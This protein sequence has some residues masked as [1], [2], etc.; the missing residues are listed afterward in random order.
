M[1]CGTPAAW[2]QAP[3]HPGQTNDENGCTH[4]SDD[5]NLFNV[6]VVRHLSCP[7]QHKSF[8]P[9]LNDREQVTEIKGGQTSRLAP[10]QR[11]S[12]IPSFLG[13]TSPSETEA[14]LSSLTSRDSRNLLEDGGDRDDTSSPVFASWH[15]HETSHGNS[16][17]R[18]YSANS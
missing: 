9:E 18:F 5:I 17:L 2:L 3:S 13:E 12:S 14:H 11:F 16:I 1:C 4:W 8:I 6:A 15:M 10:D 7:T